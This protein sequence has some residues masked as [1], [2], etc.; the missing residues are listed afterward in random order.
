M[1]V[2]FAPPQHAVDKHRRRGSVVRPL[3]VKVCLME[4]VCS[5]DGEMVIPEGIA[6]VTLALQIGGKV[7]TIA[8]ANIDSLNSQL[9]P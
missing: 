7:A 6:A 2:Y 5:P 9:N 1:E 3:E 4:A 8:V